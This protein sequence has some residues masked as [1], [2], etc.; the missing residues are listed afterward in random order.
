M[1]S[2]IIPAYNEAANL[3]PVVSALTEHLL[4]ERVADFELIVV[5]DGSSDETGD[6]IRAIAQSNP[7]V[8]VL[9][10]PVNRGIGAA[11]KSGLRVARGEYVCVSSADG[12]IAPEDI[13]QLYRLADGADL[14]TSARR[15]I[16]LQNRNFISGVHNGLIRVLFGYSMSG[17]EG[18]YVVRR[19][20][21]ADAQIVSDTSLANLELLMHA[22]RKAQRSRSGEITVRPRLS[23]T[24]KVANVRAILRVMGDMVV[25]RCKKWF[26]ALR[27]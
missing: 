15:R 10:H 13:V 14:V 5:N 4:R 20:L 7:K 26:L 3:A 2:I 1:L 6:A 24:S 8:V 9:E 11:I 27:P 21:L 25:L 23:G 22:A 19:S 18:I 16:G 17:R 12:E